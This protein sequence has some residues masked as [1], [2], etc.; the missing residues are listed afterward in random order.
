MGNGVFDFGSYYERVPDGVAF[1][2]AEWLFLSAE[3]ELMQAFMW[4]TNNQCY[5]SVGFPGNDDPSSSGTCTLAGHR[6]TSYYEHGEE[7]EHDVDEMAELSYKE[8]FDKE[9]R[10]AIK[11]APLT[12]KKPPAL[13]EPGTVFDEAFVL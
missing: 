10:R 7:Q 9:V 12:F 5:F 8:L 3:Q 2:G 1:D 6:T 11:D 4:F 13:F